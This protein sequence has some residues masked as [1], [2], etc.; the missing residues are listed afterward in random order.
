M[1]SSRLCSI[2]LLLVLKNKDD[3]FRI[4]FRSRS[5][6]SEI[7]W[8]TDNDTWSKSSRSL[9]E[10]SALTVCL[11]SWHCI[12]NDSISWEWYCPGNGS[13][14]DGITDWGGIITSSS[15]GRS[16]KRNSAFKRGYVSPLG[17]ETSR[18]EIAWI[19]NWVFAV[20]EET[21]TN[22]FRVQEAAIDRLSYLIL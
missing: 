13:S 12:G 7:V 18:W 15:T 4:A 22:S 19:S 5:G 14:C 8:R 11:S 21:K 3:A 20:A 16:P 17:I 1:I 6:F 9:S 10:L 2:L